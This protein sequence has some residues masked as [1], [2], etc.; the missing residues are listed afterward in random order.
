MS[1]LYNINLYSTVLIISIFFLVYLEKIKADEEVKIIS[2]QISIDEFNEKIIASGDAIAINENNIKLKSDE[3]IYNR[4]E[5]T[6]DANGN[7]VINDELNNTFFFEK[8]SST[9][10]LNQMSGNEVIM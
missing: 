1:K 4:K 5:S 7:V 8:L 10:N 3:I 2:D 6:I 9:D